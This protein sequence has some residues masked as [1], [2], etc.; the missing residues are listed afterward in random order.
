MTQYFIITQSN[1]SEMS[2]LGV[3]G[4]MVT[5]RYF[6]S[7]ARSKSEIIKCTGCPLLLLA[8]WLKIPKKER[9]DYQ[10]QNS[11]QLLPVCWSILTRWKEGLVSWIFHGSWEKERIYWGTDSSIVSVLLQASSQ[12]NCQ[13]RSSFHFPPPY[14]ALHNIVSLIQRCHSQCCHKANICRILPGTLTVAWDLMNR[15][16]PGQREMI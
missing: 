7:W 8:I 12:S 3:K 13:V 10:E 5:G 6:M 16:E 9:G 14:Q 2:W 15:Q 11:W 1:I 4:W